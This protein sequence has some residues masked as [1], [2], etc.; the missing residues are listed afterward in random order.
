M[1]RIEVRFDDVTLR[2]VPLDRPYIT[3]G[4]SSKNDIVVDNM[5]VSRKHARIYQEGPRFIVEDLKSLNGTFVNNKKVSQW[6]LSDNDQIL[7]GK[8]TL[9][10]VD[11]ED[12][13]I[14]DSTPSHSTIV[15]KTLVL[16]TKRQRQLLG[17]TEKPS[18]EKGNQEIRGG[19]T[20]I[21][22]GLGQKEI[23]LTKRLTVAGKG[24]HADIKLKGL[25]VGR[26]VFL[27]SQ[28]PSGFYISS[29]GGR[30]IPRVNGIPVT[31]QQRLKDGDIVS[32][33]RIKMQFYLKT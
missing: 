16:D 32:A 1:A 19:L 17:E 10:F 15:E 21:S 30:T 14:S 18:S 29:S 9:V 27:I 6:I 33:G 4:R 7:I 8:H 11:E 25:F 28:R 23:E 12:E 20:I 13:P 2:Q 3:I 24:E 31:D 22:G 5:A 26:T